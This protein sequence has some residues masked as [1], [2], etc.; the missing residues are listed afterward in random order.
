[1][2]LSRKRGAG[3][4]L[5]MLLCALPSV[6]TAG[7]SLLISRGEASER[8][9]TIDIELEPGVARLLVRRTFVNEG[10]KSADLIVTLD[11]PQ[12]GVITS[13]AVDAGEVEA[14][15]FGY[16]AAALHLPNMPARAR[17][18]VEYTVE[19]PLVATHDRARIRFWPAGE[20]E[21]KNLAA[22]IVRHQGE[23]LLPVPN[24]YW[25]EYEVPA[26]TPPQGQLRWGAFESVG[27][28]IWRVEVDAPHILS[29][30]P[31]D[32]FVCFVIDRSRS[33]TRAGVVRQL[34]I[35]ARWAQQQPNAR[36][37]VIAHARTAER[38]FDAPVGASEIL[39]LTADDPRL[40]VANGSELGAALELATDV[41][42]DAAGS[43]YL[44]V[45]S[46]AELASRLTPERLQCTC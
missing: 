39:Q 36:Y 10:R 8:S 38:L 37:Q 22:M 17:R 27:G 46:D 20:D 9:H 35:L 42:A 14:Q 28:V 15:Y 13:V 25:R 18:T 23:E 11:L 4:L 7:D 34:R 16:G 33:Q 32:P 2:K 3:V 45:L 26:P 5:A 41:L 29:Q 31:R 44:V 1:M 24:R 12:E 6:A 43:S 21:D 30:P 19:L 40:A